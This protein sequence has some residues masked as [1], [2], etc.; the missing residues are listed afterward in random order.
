M[1]EIKK[2]KSQNKQPIPA[3]IEGTKTILYKNEINLKYKKIDFSNYFPKNEVN[4]FGEK[5]VEKNINNI[6]LIINGE[7]SKLV[8]KY[9]LKEGENNIK[10]IIKNKLTDL[11]YMFCGCE[12]LIDINELEFLNTND[13][14]NF[15]CMFSGCS[16]LSDIKALQ[17]WN[18]SNGNNLEI[19]LKVCFT[20]VPHY[21][22]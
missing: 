18:V 16:S 17:N 14:N 13:V 6:D 5:F 15:E 8:E 7:K 4:I 3:P 20:N 19:I 22:I 9:K 2:E 11:G 21:Q 1:S 12:T 10:I